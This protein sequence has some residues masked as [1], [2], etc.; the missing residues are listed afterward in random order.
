MKTKNIDQTFPA[1]A[2][3]E[4]IRLLWGQ[5]SCHVA[6]SDLKVEHMT[7]L[8]SLLYQWNKALN[9]TAVRNPEDMVVLHIIDS[10][11][12][13]PCI[14]GNNIADVGTG[15]GFPGLVLAILHPE[16]KFTLI[17]SVSKKISF[18]KNA[19]AVLKLGNV[20]PVNGR[21][22]ELQPEELFDCIVSR[23]FAPLDKIVNWCRDLLTS[24]GKFV[25]MKANLSDEELGNVPKDVVIDRIEKLNVPGLNAT[26]QAVVMSLRNTKQE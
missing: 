15:P 7:T 11:S 9:L 24:E 18:V 20:T 3:K 6:I 19:V 14:Y 12:V 2:I 21:C 17:D 1:E 16:I 8:I 23:A 4:K 26:R 10:I 25:A 5:S 22:E 13:E